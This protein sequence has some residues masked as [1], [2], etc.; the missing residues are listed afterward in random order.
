MREVA[1]FNQAQAAKGAPQLST[2]LEPP[3]AG[4]TSERVAEMNA[5]DADWD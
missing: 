4:E 3:S 5:A 1:A 2:T